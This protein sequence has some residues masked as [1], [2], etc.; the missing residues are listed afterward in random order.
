MGKELGTYHLRVELED[1][2]G[3]IQKWNTGLRY[4][5][6]TGDDTKLDAILVRPPWDTEADLFDTMV[7]IYTEG[8][9]SC[10]CNKMFCLC[11]AY[12]KPRPKGK[13]IQCGN[14]MPLRRLTA[15]RPDA[16]EAVI[17]DSTQGGVV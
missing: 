3:W 1:G 15:I 4:S 14:T 11:R 8:S 13:K 7:Y 16:S 17:F 9:Y 6:G 2:R 10:D 12:Q 5:H